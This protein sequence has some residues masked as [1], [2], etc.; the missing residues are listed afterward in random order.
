M[1]EVHIPAKAH[2]IGNKPE[3]GNN[4]SVLVALFGLLQCCA[5]NV[6]HMWIISKNQEGPYSAAGVTQ[7]GNQDFRAGIENCRI[8]AYSFFWLSTH[9]HS[10]KTHLVK[11]KFYCLYR[12]RWPHTGQ[13]DLGYSRCP[14][15]F[16]TNHP[17]VFMFIITVLQKHGFVSMLYIETITHIL[18]PV[19]WKLNVLH[20]KIRDHNRQG[21]SVHYSFN[22]NIS[23]YAQIY[24]YI[25]SRRMWNSKL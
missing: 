15:T 21:T 1:A 7:L 4:S 11:R 12:L 16:L 10:D 5:I 13:V 18:S 23:R 2:N 6:R 24:L 3:H 25:K 8:R 17:H 14:L 22:P 9:C 20:S 19:K